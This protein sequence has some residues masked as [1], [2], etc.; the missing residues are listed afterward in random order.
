[1]K[2]DPASAPR[3]PATPEAGLSRRCLFAAGAGTASALAAA[4]VLL[5]RSPIQAPAAAL[6][7]AESQA[8]AAADGYRLSDHVKRYSRTAR[9]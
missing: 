2:T 9:L 7:A 3:A 1:M 4:A 6:A 8:P 5:P